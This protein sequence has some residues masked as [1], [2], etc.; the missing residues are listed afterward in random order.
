[1]LDFTSALY[2]G[3]RHPSRSLHAWASLTTGRPAALETPA[4]A[5]GV[6]RQL[7]ALQGCER[8]T[9]LPSTLHLFW[10][11]F[12]LL[13]RERVRIYMDAGTYAIARWGVERAGRHVLVRRFPHYDA[14]AACELIERDEQHGGCPII[15]ADGFCPNCGRGAPIARLLQCVERRRGKLVLDDTQ[16]LGVLGERSRAATPYGHGG[17]GAP[18]WHGV[19]SPDVIVGASLAKGFGV[20]I[21]VLCGSDA[22]IRRFDEQSETRL[23]SSPPSVAVLRAA[24]HALA[25]NNRYG[26]RWRHHLSRLV[27][28][29][30]AQLRRIGLTACGGLFP[31][32]TLDPVEGVSAE[33][34]HL[35]LLRRGIR[36]VLVRCCHGLGTRLAFLITALHRPAEIDRVIEALE[37]AVSGRAIK[38]SARAT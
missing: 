5:I 15:L 22:V 28:R 7:A 23:H 12:G 38:L 8:A 6:A 16:A 37:G 25:M 10:D 13:A 21:A 18:K 36:T 33:T 2:L 17:G 35:H 27:E 4:S 20:P 3:L 29:F 24:E 32:Q 34:L 14:A 31:A 19:G 30:R 9:L 1:M 11:L 26:D